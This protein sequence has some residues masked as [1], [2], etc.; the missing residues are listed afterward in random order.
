M[1]QNLTKETAMNILQ[2]NSSARREGSHSSKL[3]E[4]LVRRLRDDNPDATVT[5]RDLT[6]H[7]HPVLDEVALGA[8]FTPAAQRRG[9]AP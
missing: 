8:L 9:T 2:I 4:R 3:A 7:P 6:T 1:P 5:V